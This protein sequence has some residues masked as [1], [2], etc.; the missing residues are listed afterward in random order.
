MIVK[1]LVGLLFAHGITGICYAGCDVVQNSGNTYMVVGDYTEQSTC[2]CNRGDE[3]VT[4][5]CEGYPGSSYAGSALQVNRPG[6]TNG[7][8]HWTCRATKD[9]VFT[10]SRTT[11]VC[12][13]PG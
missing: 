2:S 6:L 3:I 11:I 4:G 12:R 10:Q 8:W 5:G 13:R 9:Q 1:I 7:Q